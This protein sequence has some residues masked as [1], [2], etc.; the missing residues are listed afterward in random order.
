MSE[1]SKMIRFLERH[2]EDSASEGEQQANRISDELAVDFLPK[3]QDP[4]PSTVA[5]K[6]DIWTEKMWGI[7]Q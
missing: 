5:N 2:I 1:Q 4:T 7:K 3:I 6:P